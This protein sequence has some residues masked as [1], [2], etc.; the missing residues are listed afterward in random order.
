MAR[1]QP[2][3][4][5]A[6]A[7]HGLR[8]QDITDPLLTFLVADIAGQGVGCGALR[9]IEPGVGRE[10]QDARPQAFKAAMT[11]AA[12]TTFTWRGKMRWVRKS[13]TAGSW[14]AQQSSTI[15]RR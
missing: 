7:I 8:P 2:L 15:T 4:Y 5:L 10:I 6:V 9:D 3:R 14:S 1:G 11:S 12:L 13:W